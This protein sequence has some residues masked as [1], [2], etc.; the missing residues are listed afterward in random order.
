MIPSPPIVGI[1]ASAGGV[2]A[3]QSL[4][5]AVPE[6]LGVAFVI[7]VHL[8]PERNS[9]LAHILS[10]KTK[11]PVTQVQVPTPLEANHVYVIPPDRQLE[12]VDNHIAAHEFDEPRGR[13]APIDLFF[14][15]LAKEHGDGYAIIL[16]GA[17]SD[18]TLG[19][20]AVKEAGGIILVQDPHEAE[21][22]SMPRSAIATGLV[23]F[24]GPLKALV[25]RLVELVRNKMHGPD[26][27]LQDGDEYVIRRILSYLHARTG[28]DFSQYKKS[29]ILRRLARRMQVSRRESLNDYFNYMR[30]NVE[31]VQAL[32]SDLLISVTTFFRDPQAFEVLASRAIPQLFAYRQ[33]ADSIRV[34]VPGCATGEEAYTI[35]IL[36]LEEAAHRDIRPQIQVF[37]SDL[38]PGGLAVAR[39]G[40]YP[41]GIEAS[42]SKERLQRFFWQEPDHYRARRELRDVILFASHSVLKDP[43]FSR[44]DLISCRNL[45]IYLDRELQQ[46][47]CSIFHYALK[48][49][50]Y[51]FVGLSETA[52]APQGLFR[53]VDRDARIYQSTGFGGGDKRHALPEILGSARARVQH[54]HAAATVPAE[55]TL[56]RAALETHAP[57]SILVDDR[58]V[59]LH[60]SETAGRYLEPSGGR[61]TS[62]IVELIRPELRLDLRCALRDAFERGKSSLSLPI[63]VRFN[64]LLQRVY[65]QVKPMPPD[66]QGH[67]RQALVLI[68]EGGPVDV[69]AV[70]APAIGD[71]EPVSHETV[72]KLRAELAHTRAQLRTVMEDSEVANEDLRAANEELQSI[73]EEYRSTCE[74][75]ETSKEELQSINEELQTVNNELKLKF[76]GLARA[77]DDLQNLMGATDIGTLFL[78]RRLDIK[79]FTP[80]ITDIFSIQ[81]S[82]AGRPI[83]DFSHQ[84]EYDDLL[85]DAAAVMEDLIPIEREARDHSGHWYLIRFR[86]YRTVDDRIDGV[87]V[88]FVDVTQRRRAEEA[89]K[90]SE[91]R[92]RQK[93]RL[94]ENSREPIFNWD[95]DHGILDWNLGCE[96]LYGYSRQEAIGHFRDDLLRTTVP[97][98]SIEKLKQ[99]LLDHN[100]WSGELHQ[101]TK[102]GRELTVESRVELLA[103]GE[104]LVALESTRDITQRK[105]WEQRQQLLL[106]EL[107]HRVKNTLAVV[108]SM[109]HQTLR[110]SR[111][112]KD[113]VERFDGRLHALANA[114]KLLV[115]LD[116]KG[117]ELAALARHQLAP[118]ASDNG[119]RLLMK[120]DPVIVPAE[121]VTSFG[122]VLH[123]L[124]TNAVKHG[125]LKVPG[126]KVELNWSLQKD[127]EQNV[128]LTL[129]WRERDGPP[130]EP[131]SVTGFGC[132]LITEGLPQASVRHEFRPDGVVCT[133]EL[134][135]PG[136]AF[137]GQV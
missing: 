89:L 101:I 40:R 64:G 95:F 18:G 5:E 97:R 56:H 93:T 111:S 133:I 109:A 54:A 16:T 59:V 1:G 121:Y 17:G 36:L 112:A 108:Q 6:G 85:G 99:E 52:D 87:V 135:L 113:F 79:W 47:V 10:G 61:L 100:S 75:L 115:D 73:N 69:A 77:H 74:E 12:I 42:V 51:L 7:I 48:P 71:E 120:G 130:V 137:V 131:A 91:D 94:I 134:L 27:R 29:T 119:G 58:L 129:V 76:Q 33:D 136:D 45:L 30:G 132:R 96:K 57:P 3:L 86:P 35:A 122:L 81:A 32:F 80:R 23:D 19:L 83:G 53:V 72:E 128:M 25:N 38:D 8:A 28:H 67:V 20:K 92:L 49:N 123:E 117:A 41:L 114:H 70:D 9:E 39:E 68:I 21:Y 66:R 31:E 62:Q 82:D 107:T 34:W 127:G 55:T 50:G 116:W 43:P 60:L 125:A 118:Y 84:L 15:S 4:L 104:H 14:Q 126:G 37:A 44:L 102:D 26:N 2:K 22:P 11:L 105:Y 98:S 46:Q 124:S 88:T 63:I 90:Q 24:V 103:L 65:L 106:N 110:T 78:D 13:R